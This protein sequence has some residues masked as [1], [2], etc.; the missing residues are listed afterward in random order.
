MAVVD[1]VDVA[2]MAD[3][4]V[5]A[6]G[7][8]LMVMSLVNLVIAHPGGTSLPIGSWTVTVSPGRPARKPSALLVRATCRNDGPASQYA[9]SSSLASASR[10]V[11]EM[12]ALHG[13]RLSGQ[14][15]LGC[16][17]DACKPQ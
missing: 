11:L 14:P 13:K 9:S 1:I 8:V 4:D 5:S 17:A 15:W 7:P 10:R 6:V 3:R 2:L 12:A 16:G